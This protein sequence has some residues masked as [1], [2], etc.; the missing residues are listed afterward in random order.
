LVSV[1]AQGVPD[2]IDL[3]ELYPY[4]PEEA[5]RLL[6]EL[7]YDAQ[8]LSPFSVLVS[9]HDSTLADV[10][11]LVKSQLAKIGVEAEMNLMDLTAVIDRADTA[12]GDSTLRVAPSDAASFNAGDY[13]LL[14]SNKSVDTERSPC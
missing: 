10:A 13:A 6:K 1:L 3:N 8:H 4:R 2:A 11:A 12:R 7:G 14:Y 9:N 5:K